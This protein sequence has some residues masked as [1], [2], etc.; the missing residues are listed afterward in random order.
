MIDYEFRDFCR[1]HDRRDVAALLAM[2]S[3]QTQHYFEMGYSSLAFC[4]S[5]LPA[6]SD[7]DDARHW[8]MPAGHYRIAS[9]HFTATPPRQRL[10]P[11]TRCHR[12]PRN[13]RLLTPPCLS[14][15]LRSASSEPLSADCW[16]DD[17][18]HDS[19]IV[20]ILSEL[21]NRL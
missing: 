19:L 21:S 20:I 11:F 5:L 10:P 17:Y 4:A 13:S 18:T 16:Y 12:L 8:P 9:P 14:I 6:I 3:A 15:D 7:D 1:Y 2:N